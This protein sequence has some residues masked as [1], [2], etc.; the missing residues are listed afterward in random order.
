[1]RKKK[2]SIKIIHCIVT[3][4]Q[5]LSKNIPSVLDN[6]HLYWTDPINFRV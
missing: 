3:T 1:M 5:I 6:N 4:I 2:K